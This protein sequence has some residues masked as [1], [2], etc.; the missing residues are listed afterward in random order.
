MKKI[1]T[2]SLVLVALLISTTMAAGN[3]GTT[4]FGI[5][6]GM[7]SSNASA[8]D[9]STKDVS[10]Y[11][12]GLAVQAPLGLGFSIQP[13]IFYQMKGMSLDQA[14]SSTI[15]DV[16]GSIDIKAGYVEVPV[17]LQWGP[18]LL[19]MRPYGFVEPYVGYLVR[20]NATTLVN[21]MKKVEYGLGVGA[22]LD[23]WKLQVS[24]KWFWDFGG[25]AN[26][27]VNQSVETVKS[28]KNFNGF[29]VSLA[30]FF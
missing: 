1:L 20:D 29:A 11:H 10:L 7:T 19:L 15:S 27:D 12:L 22:G 14:S 13:G 18:D 8:K 2:S 21:E 25:I 9:F 30:I 24:A 3:Y 5:V 6:G 16:A 4:R 23:I 28:L 26:T 17:Q